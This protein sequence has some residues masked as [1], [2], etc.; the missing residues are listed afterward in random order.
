[1]GPPKRFVE[2]HLPDA[3]V[4]EQQASVI[5][6]PHVAVWLSDMPNTMASRLHVYVPRARYA[7]RQRDGVHLAQQVA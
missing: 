4:A 5:D 3:Q 7:S 6:E 2:I 1:M